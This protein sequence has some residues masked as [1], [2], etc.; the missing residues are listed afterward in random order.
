[1]S[2]ASALNPGGSETTINAQ[3]DE[4]ALKNSNKR[5]HLQHHCRQSNPAVKTNGKDYKEHRSSRREGLARSK[6]LERLASGCATCKSEGG[7]LN[8]QCPQKTRLSSVCNVDENVETRLRA[9]PK[10]FGATIERSQHLSNKIQGE[11][12]D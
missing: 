11:L 2:S 8:K 3:Q 10:G 9:A 12:G 6:P 5:A 7:R 4:K 1:M